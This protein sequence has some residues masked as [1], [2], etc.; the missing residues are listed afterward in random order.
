MASLL[1]K[2]KEIATIAY[3][4]F[5]DR[6]NYYGLQALLILFLTKYYYLS[7]Q[8]S[9]VIYGTYTALSFGFTILGGLIADK[10]LGIYGAT[11]LGGFLISIGNLILGFS[12]IQFVYIGLSVIV[13]GIGLFKPNNPN[14]LGI[15]YKKESIVRTKAFS[16]FYLC[17]N[18]GSVLGP[19]FYGLA[20]SHHYY[21]LAFS[22][23]AIGMLSALLY[24]YIFRHSLMQGVEPRKIFSSLILLL[25]C[26]V[27]TYLLLNH[28]ELF[29]KFLIV[30]AIVAVFFLL[31]F[32]NALSPLERKSIASLFVPIAGCI[33]FFASFLQ[34]YSTLTLFIDRYVNKQIF[35]WE[36]PTTWF[37]S[38]EPIF[39]ILM[40]PVVTIIWEVLAKKNIEP[41]SKT[42]VVFGLVL[43]AISF[44]I[45][46]I[47]SILNSNSGHAS[48]VLIVAA[49]IFLAIS[50]LCIIPVT[51]SLTNIMAPEKYRGTMMGI[52]YF[53][54]TLSSYLAGFIAK[55]TQSVSKSNSFP[56]FHTFS[57]IAVLLISTAVLLF[58]VGCLEDY[59]QYAVVA[60]VVFK[61]KKILK[62]FIG[63]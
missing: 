8:N 49:N 11:L 16:V 7:D 50:E 33:V 34:I 5:W 62:T 1:R 26:F 36:I 63:Y 54:L 25:G 60:L 46:A 37:S 57:T 38:L 35:G 47:S 24:L 14:L 41:K 19:V 52:F 61:T 10:M 23:S 53:S 58:L 27:A 13:I 44:C 32:L 4:E 51:M 21:R 18:V 20:S 28:V 59:K 56:F 42:K 48:L 43:A 30:V 17:I 9:Y 55:F 3:A 2:N 31:K 22:F 29:A 39:I 6:F 15:I 12:G 45:F 40:V